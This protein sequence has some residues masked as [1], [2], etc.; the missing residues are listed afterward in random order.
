MSLLLEP[1]LAYTPYLALLVRVWF[2]A[3]L[4]IHGRPKLN[5]ERRAQSIANFQAKGVPPIAVILG[6]VLE[7][8]G[9]LFLVIGLIVPV[10]ATFEAIYFASIIATKK[11]KDHAQYVAFGK[12]NYELEVAFVV[13]SIVLIFLGA[14]AFSLDGLVGL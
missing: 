1:L 12:P 10:A 7:F 4:M 11:T 14:G 13:V 8:F 9:G 2:G 3:T 6:T 5:K